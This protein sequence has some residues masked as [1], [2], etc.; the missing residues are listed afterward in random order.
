MSIHFPL[1]PDSLRKCWPV[2]RPLTF[3]YALRNQGCFSSRTKRSRHST[4]CCCLQAGLACHMQFDTPSALMG[5]WGHPLRYNLLADI[6]THEQSICF[7]FPLFRSQLFFFHPI[8]LH[9]NYLC[10]THLLC[11]PVVLVVLWKQ[12]LL[13]TWCWH[14]KAHTALKDVLQWLER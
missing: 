5:M 9:T 2:S 6:N 11:N 14:D 1:Q 12:L 4:S 8:Q 3:D 10:V 7:F 13:V